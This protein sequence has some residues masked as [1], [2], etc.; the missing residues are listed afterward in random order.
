MYTIIILGSV[1][2]DR[3]VEL[4]AFHCAALDLEIIVL[5]RQCV[6]PNTNT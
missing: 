1:I 4:C 3:D 6:I 5:D 2:R